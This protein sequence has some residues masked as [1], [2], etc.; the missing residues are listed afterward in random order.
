ML[1]ILHLT[2]FGTICFNSDTY[3]RLRN[4][5]DKLYIDYYTVTS[6][7][8]E[9][10]NRDG[11]FLRIKFDEFKASNYIHYE[12]LKN[13]KSIA[14]VYTEST[15]GTCL[16]FKLI[17]LD[18]EGWKIFDLER[19]KI[20][21]IQS[22]I[23]KTKPIF[24]FGSVAA[25][26]P[27]PLGDIFKLVC[28]LDC[29]KNGRNSTV[30]EYKIKYEDP[31]SRGEISDTDT[32]KLIKT[33]VLNSGNNRTD[34]AAIESDIVDAAGNV[35]R[36]FDQFMVDYQSKYTELSAPVETV[37]ANAA[38]ENIR[39]KSA[40]YPTTRGRV[41]GIVEGTTQISNMTKEGMGIMPSSDYSSD[42][43]H[44]GGPSSY[45]TAYPT[46]GQ[47]IYDSN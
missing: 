5:G 6:P 21:D 19:S 37:Y 15:N 33:E 13:N 46:S 17:K 29:H 39:L 25:V 34:L 4:K 11:D 45:Q 32:W 30:I 12:K 1:R 44:M 36:S 20:N 35:T 31:R 41:D 7:A 10:L 23:D 2:F 22:L 38:R 40:I 8:Y 14:K 26:P 3:K 16:Q 28:Q 43:T 18:G 24:M 9:I 42:V 27:M 47:I